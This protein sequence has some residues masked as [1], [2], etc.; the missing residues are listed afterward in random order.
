MKFEKLM[1]R[2]KRLA[3]KVAQREIE[4]ILAK[5]ELVPGVSAEPTSEGVIL[6]GKNLKARAVSDPAVRDVAR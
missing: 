2:A 3:V 6:S 5:A 1:A 4:R